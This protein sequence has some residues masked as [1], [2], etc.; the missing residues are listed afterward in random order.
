MS[1]RC[2][3]S[4]I[5]WFSG[6]TVLAIAL[7][8]TACRSES[9]RAE[10]AVREPGD[11]ATGDKIAPPEGQNQKPG[12]EPR[13]QAERVGDKAEQLAR[14]GQELGREAREQAERVGEKAEQLAER[15][16]EVGREANEQMNRVGE[17]TGALKGDRGSGA[18]EQAAP[19]PAPRD[20]SA[21]QGREAQGQTQGR[22]AQGQTQGR[23]AQGQTQGREAQ[24]QTQGRE[25]QGQTGGARD[26]DQAG[27]AV[28]S[29][30]DTWTQEAKDNDYQ[31]SFNRDGSVVA[32]KE[33]KGSGERL[34]DEALRNEVGGKLADSDHETVK[35]LSVTVHNGVVTLQ[36]NVAS[37]KEAT[38]AVKEALEAKG[39]TKVISQ[40]RY[41]SSP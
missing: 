21:P 34:A 3:M 38:E 14:E 12:Q 24:G 28:A 16:R 25:A 22:E 27:G 31:V 1:Y 26:K 41:G 19:T 20:Q 23:A 39:V 35:K 5:R 4:R 7:V 2:T 13:G 9:E 10:G 15:G 30:R 37:V 6:A 17:Q 29:T 32:T 11:R 40:I 33:A 8:G 18:R 36:G